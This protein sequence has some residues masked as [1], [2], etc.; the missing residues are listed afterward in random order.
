MNNDKMEFYE[1][2]LDRV[3]QWLN[4]AEAKNAALIAFILAILSV[5]FGYPF[6]EYMVIS[7]I[8]AICYIIALCISLKSFQPRY[9]KDATIP[10]EKYSDKDNMLFW[11]DISKYSRSDYV[12]KVN[13]D[14]CEKGEESKT[15]KTRERWEFLYAEEI[16][17]N[18]RIAKKKYELFQTALR[19]VI[20]GT[21]MV[22]IALLIIA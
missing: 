4:F 15:N 3:N 11:R 2:S 19:F 7:T 22:P 21:I 17:I 16:I 1:K 20:V 8:I 6:E 9:D 12:E 5:I 14:F 10:M 18:A 13:L